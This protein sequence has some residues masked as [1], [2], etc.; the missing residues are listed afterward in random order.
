MDPAFVG[1]LAMPGFSVQ[2]IRHH[3]E[4]R[5]G[6]L[7]MLG[8]DATSG[9]IG[10]GESAEAVAKQALGSKCFDCV[11]IG[12]GL[13]EPPPR[14]LLFERM[15]NLVLVMAPQASICFTTTPAAP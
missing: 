14:L 12:A 11:V 4:A 2:Q 6:Q 5:I 13:R 7:R 15:I 3:I 9:L 10:S 8:F 1:L